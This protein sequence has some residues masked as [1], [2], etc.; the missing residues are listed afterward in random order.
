M[1]SFL[2]AIATLIATTVGAE[3]QLTKMTIA[4]GVDLTQRGVDLTRE[5]LALEGLE[6]EVRVADAEALPFED[7][8]FD[9]V[10]SW[11]V[12]HHSP[13]TQQ[14][15]NEV[16]RVLK[17]GGVARVMIVGVSSVGPMAEPRKTSRVVMPSPTESPVAIAGGTGSPAS[18]GL[19]GLPTG[20]AMHVVNGLR[21]RPSW[22]HYA[23]FAPWVPSPLVPRYGVRSRQGRDRIPLSQR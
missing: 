22:V 9:I 10:Y 16:H 2:A 4:T 15:V 14:A 1:R 19:S 3:A 20:S 23:P 13:N 11:G 5:R 17:P 7:A 18:A 8:S 6:A 12:L 21:A